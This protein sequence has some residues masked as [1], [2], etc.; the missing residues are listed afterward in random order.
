M[1]EI[2]KTPAT[3][4]QKRCRFGDMWSNLPLDLLANIF[5]YF[6][7]ESLARAKSAC[8]NW[9]AAA[10]AADTLAVRRRHPPW[11][12]ALPAGVSS[13]YAYNPIGDN[14]HLLS[15]DCNIKP[16]STICG[17]ILSKLTATTSL[18]L[19]VCNPFTGQ[20]RNLPA[21]KMP[22]TNPAVGTVAGA[23]GSSNSSFQ[24]YVAGGMSA[25]ATSGGAAY[26]PTVET[27]DSVSDRWTVVGAMPAAFAVRLTVW[28]PRESVHSNGT[29]YWMTSARAYS[30]VGFEIPTGRWKELRVPMAERLD[31]A[32]LVPRNGRLAAVGGVCGG[33]DASVWEL[34]EGDAWCLVETVPCELGKRLLGEKRNWASVKCAAIDG[35]VCLY[36][37]LGSG[38]IIW[39]EIFGDGKKW[40]WDWIEGCC[41]IKG[42]QIRNI[43]INGFF[44]RPNLARSAFSG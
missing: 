26:Q 16:I 4:C 19:S 1:Q 39:R 27:Y 15:L 7:P 44:I 30:V 10:E 21:L 20:F 2:I 34:G 35:A 38:I 25:A 14:W 12:V 23:G 41:S 3:I 32:A 13:C 9:H 22:R 17:L 8:R 37:D 18:Q 40:E 36:R 28:T 6:P 29:L 5:S 31:F 24:I 11:F 42:I 33:G 43:P